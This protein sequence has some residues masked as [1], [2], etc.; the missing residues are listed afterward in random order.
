MLA[1]DLVTLRPIEPDDIATLASFLNDLEVSLLVGGS[2]PVPMPVASVTA[3][4]ERRRESS[5]EINFAITA[6]DAGARLIGQCGLFRHDVVSR[7][8]EL[9]IS[10]GHREYWGRHYGRE[11]VSLLVDYAFRIRNLRKV[12]LTVNASN[13]R[14]I[15]AYAA[16]GFV[17]EGRRARHVWNNGRYIDIVLMARFAEPA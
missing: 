3:L 2:A 12:C 13:Q 7:T 8:A 4:H 9:G 1:G 16:A 15:R 10:I 17:E 11:A 5:D 14:A 6:T